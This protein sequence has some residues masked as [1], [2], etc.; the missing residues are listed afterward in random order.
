[1][2]LRQEKE[3]I[4]EETEE[5]S[6]VPLDLEL[7]EPESWENMKKRYNLEFFIFCSRELKIIS[8]ICDTFRRKNNLV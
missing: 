2:I 4:V 8:D 5:N 3:S 6:G 7:F 1:M